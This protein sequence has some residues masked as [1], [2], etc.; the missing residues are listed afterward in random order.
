MY[1]L[2]V[3]FRFN[4]YETRELISKWQYN[5]QSIFVTK[6][7]KGQIIRRLS[8]TIFWLD[9]L[10]SHLLMIFFLLK[11]S[12]HFLVFITNPIWRANSWWES[13]M[14]SQTWKVIAWQQV[15]L[16]HISFMQIRKV[17]ICGHCEYSIHN[18]PNM[19]TAIDSILRVN[20]QTQSKLNLLP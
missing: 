9:H 3:C 17:N 12:L 6:D 15:H 7:N 13:H 4:L 10:F 14:D 1:N 20:R 18:I 5:Y 19:T 2:I 11:F 8:R 16:F